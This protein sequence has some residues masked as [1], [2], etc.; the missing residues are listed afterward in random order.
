MPRLLFEADDAKAFTIFSYK[1]SAHS[2]LEAPGGGVKK[3]VS[4]RGR[5]L[6]YLKGLLLPRRIFGRS[7]GLY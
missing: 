6:Q 1:F 5:L 4:G 3:R 7:T 2:R